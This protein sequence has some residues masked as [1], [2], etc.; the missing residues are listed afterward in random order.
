M[1]HTPPAMEDD[2]IDRATHTEGAELWAPVAV[3]PEPIHWSGSLPFLAMHAG[4][5]ALFWVGVSPIAVA[6][7][8]AL[9]VLRMF[10]ITGFYHRYFSH[11]T[12]HTGR[13]FQF[14]MALS[15]TL[16]VQRGP[17]WWAAHHR[18]HHR[19][20]DE[21]G[22]AH[23]P[24]QHGFWWSHVGWF[25]TQS[26][27]PTREHLVRD[28][29]RYPELRF[30]DRW[31]LI[32]PVLLAAGLLGLGAWLHVAF[33]RLGTSAAQLFVWGFVVSTVAVYHATYT[34]NSLSHRFGSRRFDTGDDSRNNWLLALITLGEGWH[35][36]HH[37]Y[38]GS[39]RQG[40]YWWEIDL[41][42][43]GLR[44]LA[45]LGIISDLRP[46]PAKVL[47]DRRLP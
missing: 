14:V 18:Y 44:L 2:A 1:S 25:L 13:V 22:D 39:A 43:Y 19:H 6:F 27:T 16:A 31:F 5:L 34:I 29:I 3:P 47:E 10:A 45:V 30:V 20:S 40:F 42:Y 11:R 4:V 24:G 38:P 37:H 46:V 23:S 12:F 33:P 28:W 9:Y 26:G 8:V 15:G 32:G 36:N 35:N 7:A 17:L 41:T 21:A